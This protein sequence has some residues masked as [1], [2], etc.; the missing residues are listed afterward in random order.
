MAAPSCAGP[1]RVGGEISSCAASSASARH[2]RNAE[3]IH[4]GA[5]NWPQRP[6]PLRQRQKIPEEL[7]KLITSIR[8]FNLEAVVHTLNEARRLVIAEIKGAKRDGAQGLTVIH[9]YCSSST[10]R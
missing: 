7:R 5:E 1:A 10:G 6:L 4:P 8:T 3:A 2:L 9:G